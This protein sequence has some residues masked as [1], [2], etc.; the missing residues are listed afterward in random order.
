[1]DR[2]GPAVLPDLVASGVVRLLFVAYVVATAV[3]IGVVMAL[4]PFAFDAWNVAWDTQAP[5]RSRS[6]TSSSTASGST[7]H[8]NPRVG[9]WFTYLAYK[10][11]Y[12]AVIATP[13]AFLALA[14]AVTVLGL[15]RWPAWRRGRDL[16]LF[17]IAL[18]FLW[19]ALPRIGMIMFCRAYGANYL[20]GAVI[21]LWFLVPLRLRP[22]GAGADDRVHPV[23]PARRDRRGVQRAHRPDARAVRAR[24][25][26]L[27]PP[28]GRRAPKLALAGAFGVVVG[29]AAIFFAPGQ[30]ERYDGL[31]DQGR[32]RRAGC[33]SAASPATSTSSAA[34][35]SAPRR[36]SR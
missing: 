34:T 26:G 25:R 7:S 11:E 15:G 14:L 9:Q 27:A 29:F 21:Q 32:L 5:S 30:G 36:C 19:F 1:M 4:E 18:G 10:L 20:Y 31:A 17:A 12:F 16:A 22:D 24:L 6:A 28:P 13:L 35:S 23:L 3:H 33:S 2:A 8:S